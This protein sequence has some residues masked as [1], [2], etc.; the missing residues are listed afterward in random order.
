MKTVKEDC[1]KK[2]A[3]FR[4]DPVVR[5]AVDKSGKVQAVVTSMESIDTEGTEIILAAGCNCVFSRL[6]TSLRLQRGELSADDLG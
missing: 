3:I 2:G 6:I 5:M 1:V 4:D